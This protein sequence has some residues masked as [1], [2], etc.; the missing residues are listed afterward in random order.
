MELGSNPW[1]ILLLGMGTV[2]VGL[3]VLIALIKLLGFVVN[4]FKL[5]DAA[6]Q[7]QEALPPMSAEAAAFSAPFYASAVIEDRGRFDAIVAAAIA[8]YIGND[9]DG[10]RIHSVRRIGDDAAANRGQFVAAVSAALA[11][12]LGS[13]VDG[14]RIHSIKRVN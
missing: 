5:G 11:S 1:F 3:V 13:D 9:I 10:L 4:K 12:T 6:A 2:F 8:S 7:A 14:L